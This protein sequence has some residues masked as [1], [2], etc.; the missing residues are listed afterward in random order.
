MLDRL[1]TIQSHSSH[2]FPTS[3][4]YKIT[5]QVGVIQKTRTRIEMEIDHVPREK[6]VCFHTV[7]LLA[8][9]SVSSRS[10]F[11]MNTSS[12]MHYLC[13]LLHDPYPC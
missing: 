6:Y 13:M 7:Y 1:S 11:M 9:W 10:A 8:C 3:W 2:Q 5:R 4:R 12:V